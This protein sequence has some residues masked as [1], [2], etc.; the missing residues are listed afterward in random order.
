[1]SER[2]V[3]VTRTYSPVSG[4]AVT[5]EGVPA[6]EGTMGH[7]T[8]LLFDFAVVDRTQVL[9]H[10]ALDGSDAAELRIA[11]SA[12]DAVASGDRSLGSGIAEG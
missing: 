6:V 8:R 1:M 5:V 12:A 11:Y 7:E 9:V 4:R 2:Q 3:K 10:R